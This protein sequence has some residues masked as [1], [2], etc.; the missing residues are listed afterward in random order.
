[1]SMIPTTSTAG[2]DADLSSNE[3]AAK[4]TG[5]A[6]VFSVGSRCLCSAL[7]LPVCFGPWSSYAH[8]CLMQSRKSQTLKRAWTP[9]DD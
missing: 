6:K 4:A 3:D 5:P 2:T 7:L 1:M 8:S 9:C